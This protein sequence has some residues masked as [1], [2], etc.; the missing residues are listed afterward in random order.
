LVREHDS[1]NLSNALIRVLRDFGIPERGLGVLCYFLESLMITTLFAVY[2][3]SVVSL[4]DSL[5]HCN[6]NADIYID[7]DAATEN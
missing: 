4:E 2:E 6:H 5:P 7:I 3:F 1:E